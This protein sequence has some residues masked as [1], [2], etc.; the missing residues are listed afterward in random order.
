MIERHVTF[1]V[2][3]GQ[4]ERFETFFTAEYRPAMAAMPGFVR[5]ELLCKQDTPLQYCMTIR[6]DSLDDAAAW[7][8][9]DRHQALAPTLKS[10][11][12]ASSVVVYAVKA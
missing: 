7:R 9:S 2:L 8:L 6:F 12:A 1:E 4:G 10:M 5:V 11:Y 3:P